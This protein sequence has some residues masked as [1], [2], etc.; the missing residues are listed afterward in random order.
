MNREEL[1]AWE[2]ET[3]ARNAKWKAIRLEQL[4]KD[5]PELIIDEAKAHVVDVTD[6]KYQANNLEYYQVKH[7]GALRLPTD[8]GYALEWL[9]K[10]NTP[11]QIIETSYRLYLISDWDSCLGATVETY[12][13][14]SGRKFKGQ[15]RRRATH[16]TTKGLYI[17][18]DGKRQYL[19]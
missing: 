6:L 9:Q 1:K 16:E 17:E 18:L 7:Y 14:E 12:W 2:E 11:Y 8:L 19:R 15:R 13:K 4:R 5:F 10:Y 3:K